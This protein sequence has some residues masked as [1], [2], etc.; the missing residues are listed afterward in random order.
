[1][2]TQTEMEGVTFGNYFLTNS[3]A[4]AGDAAQKSS[5]DGYTAVELIFEIPL[6]QSPCVM[7]GGSPVPGRSQS[8]RG[9]PLGS[10]VVFSLIPP[11][12]TTPPPRAP[13]TTSSGTASLRVTT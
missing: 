4:V 10:P 1:M 2:R 8:W 5:A 12:T 9:S 7:T 6:P 11:S 3:D 13:D